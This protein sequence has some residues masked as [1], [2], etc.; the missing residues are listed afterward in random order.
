MLIIIDWSDRQRYDNGFKLEKF[1]N[2]RYLRR[3]H[4]TRENRTGN[5]LQLTV[6]P[7]YILGAVRN[8]DLT[9]LLKG[10]RRRRDG[11]SGASIMRDIPFW[12][13]IINSR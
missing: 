13:M 10:F 4:F 1:R 12:W 5:I 2:S 6:G 8:I 3:F 7:K 11:N 9:L